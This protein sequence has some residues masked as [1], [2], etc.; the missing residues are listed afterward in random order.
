NRI[1]AEL[2][3]HATVVD[4]ACGKGGPGLWVAGCLGAA[5]TG[6]DPDEDSLAVAQKRAAALGIPADYRTGTFDATGLPDATAGAIMSVDALLFAPDKRTAIHELARI[7]HL[8]GRAVLTTWDYR[9]QPPGRPP[10]ARLGE[11]FAG[12]QQGLEVA[13]HPRPAA[14][15]AGGLLR[16]GQH[17]GERRLAGDVVDQGQLGVAVR[18]F[19]DFVG[20][21]AETFGGHARIHGH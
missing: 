17:G 19:L 13:E 4:L 5:I 11:G 3:P 21:M 15:G 7:L 6:N 8:G 12:L 1:T 9:G 20:E 2:R 14:A 10:L 18:V 16:A